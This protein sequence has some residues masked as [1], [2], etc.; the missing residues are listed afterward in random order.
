M[1]KSEMTQA[2]ETLKH[3]PGS[4]GK[5]PARAACS[6]ARQR[7]HVM[8]SC[9]QPRLRLMGCASC[10]KG[11]AEHDASLA[12]EALLAQRHAEERCAY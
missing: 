1:A 10:S 3:E 11:G 8:A 5:A 4:S 9:A 2:I 6:K 7:E 12:A